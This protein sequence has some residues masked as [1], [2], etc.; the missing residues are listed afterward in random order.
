MSKERWISEQHM[1]CR[2]CRFICLLWIR[3]TG[4]SKT[5]QWGDP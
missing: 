2:I 3:Y 5:D 1:D 4:D